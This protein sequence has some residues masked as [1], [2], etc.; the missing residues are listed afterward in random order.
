[1]KA[2][3][4]KEEL[5]ARRLAVLIIALLLFCGVAG[6]GARKP[7]VNYSPVQAVQRSSRPA[8]EVELFITSKPERKYKEM[9]VLSFLTWEYNPEE[10][11]IWGI[12]RNK[13]AEIGADAIIMLDTRTETAT[14][15]ATKQTYQGKVFRAMAI[16]Y[17]E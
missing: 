7:L 12:L 2:V 15:Y 11:K 3:G 4:S 5:M 13:A 8:S 1:M 9:G 16:A 14:N 6:C 17:E 10:T